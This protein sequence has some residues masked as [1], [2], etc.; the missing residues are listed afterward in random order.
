[1]VTS[2][3]QDGNS[4]KSRWRGHIAELEFWSTNQRVLMQP[5]I[6]PQRPDASIKYIDICICMYKYICIYLIK[7]TK[8]NIKPAVLLVKLKLTLN[9]KT[10]AVTH[11]HTQL[12]SYVCVCDCK[13]ECV[14]VCLCSWLSAVSA[15][16]LSPS[17][18]YKLLS[19]DLTM[20]TSQRWT[21]TI[22]GRASD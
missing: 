4:Q 7:I 1:M 22:G 10:E 6:N 21:E 14:C 13:C 8:I 11:T 16:T 5:S 20:K 3:N 15:H 17:L 19:H 9:V 18:S 2:K 12:R